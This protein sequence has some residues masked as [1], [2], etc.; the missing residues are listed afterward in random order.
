M[1]Y[2]TIYNIVLEQIRS[3]AAKALEDEKEVIAQLAKHSQGEFECERRIIEKVI[4]EDTARLSAL[5]K[6]IGKLYEDMIAER[7]SAEN[8]NTILSKS[9]AE[10]NALRE[11]LRHS[12]TR[13]DREQQEQDDTTRWIGLIK[14][15]ANIQELDTTTLQRLIKRIVIHEDLDGGIIR[16]TVEIHFNFMGQPDTYKMIRE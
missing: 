10:Q 15:Y 14:E 1:K 4:N 9:Q 11:R 12:Q 3:Y 16:Q 2:N 5:D 7:I 6:L 8:F 13:L